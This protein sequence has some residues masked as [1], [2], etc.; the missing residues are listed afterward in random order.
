VHET[1]KYAQ[2]KAKCIIGSAIG[3]ECHSLLAQI[4]DYDVADADDD[5]DD[6]DDD[7]IRR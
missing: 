3:L 7:K 1:V 6:D 5:D 4:D 2:A